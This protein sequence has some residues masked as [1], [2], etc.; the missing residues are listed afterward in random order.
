M[1]PL[2]GPQ[3]FVNESD[4]SFGYEK[5]TKRDEIHFVYGDSSRLV[6]KCGF[7]LKNI[8]YVGGHKGT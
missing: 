2:Y 8:Y 1:P 7:T 6:T 4:V 3:P 5:H